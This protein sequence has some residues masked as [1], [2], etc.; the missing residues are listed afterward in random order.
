[1]YPIEERETIL[2]YD[3]LENRWHVWSSVKEHIAKIVE[4]G[5]VKKVDKDGRGTVRAVDAYLTA[6]QVRLFASK[7]PSEK[8]RNAAREL[9]AKRRK[10]RA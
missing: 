10:K 1:M 8:Q 4:I 9:A 2:R 3:E 6:S 7:G 5:D